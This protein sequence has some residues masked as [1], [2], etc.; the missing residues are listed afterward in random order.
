MLLQ[1]FILDF[2]GNLGCMFWEG[3]GKYYGGLYAKILVMCACV[4]GPYIEN[5]VHHH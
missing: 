1:G 3:G 5:A 4:A 2:Q